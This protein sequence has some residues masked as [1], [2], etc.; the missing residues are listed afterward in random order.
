ME[1]GRVWRQRNLAHGGL[2]S[3]TEGGRYQDLAWPWLVKEIGIVPCTLTPILKSPL[4]TFLMAKS[5][6]NIYLPIQVARSQE[7]NIDL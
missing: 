6:P 7:R 2:Q 5:Y 4:F 1:V 3:G